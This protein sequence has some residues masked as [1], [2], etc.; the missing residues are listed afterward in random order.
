MSELSAALVEFTALVW[1]SLFDEPIEPTAADDALLADPDALAGAVSI[2]G[3]W[4]GGVAV[5]QSAGS[6]RRVA[7]AMF[8]RDES[9]V[10]RQEMCDAVCEVANMVGG[11][12]KALMPSTVE[13]GLP[14]ECVLPEGGGVEL[15]ADCLARLDFDWQGGRVIVLVSGEERAA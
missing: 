8:G 15:A 14:V 12:V 9:D 1:G 4:L 3:A 2:H 11:S 6:A 5:V 10:G 7:A 13:L